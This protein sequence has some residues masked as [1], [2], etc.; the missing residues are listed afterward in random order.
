MFLNSNVDGMSIS[1]AIVIVE[2]LLF[3]IL[4]LVYHWQNK[5]ERQEGR[6]VGIWERTFYRCIF[7]RHTLRFSNNYPHGK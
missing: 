2:R 3:I 6:S 4:V 1:G 5:T 7:N